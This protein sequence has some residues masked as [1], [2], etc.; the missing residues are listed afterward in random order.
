M[1]GMIGYAFFFVEDVRS[2]R[3][4]PDSGPPEPPSNHFEKLRG[5]LEVY[6]SIRVDKRWQLVFQ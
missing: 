1:L 3:I 6:H 2:Q 4:P 5:K